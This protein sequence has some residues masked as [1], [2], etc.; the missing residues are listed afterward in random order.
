VR[1]S[2]DR[3]R[4]QTQTVGSRA[5]TLGGPYS[6]RWRRSPGEMA[7][8]YSCRGRLNRWN[9]NS[10]PPR[11]ANIARKGSVP[12]SR[13]RPRTIRITSKI[14]EIMGIRIPKNRPIHLAPVS[15]LD[16]PYYDGSGE[17]RS[18]RCSR[19]SRAAGCRLSRSLTCAIAPP[20][21]S[22]RFRCTATGRPGNV[23]AHPGAST[24]TALQ[25]RHGGR[26]RGLARR[27]QGL[28]RTRGSPSN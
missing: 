26:R 14:A 7:S 25:D 16:N 19:R 2:R 8:G 13:M 18:V 28:L 15:T 17:W 27:R 24:M 9:S 5:F 12:M 21:S 23:P 4:R 6:Y 22:T 10:A 20:R 1:R 11:S 3:G